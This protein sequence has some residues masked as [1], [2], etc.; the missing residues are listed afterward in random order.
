MKRMQETK[1]TLLNHAGA[2]RISR[3]DLISIPTPLATDTFKPVPHDQLVDLVEKRLGN[4]GMYIAKEEY[5]V[6]TAG[7][8]LFGT[9]TLRH[10]TRADFSFTIGLRTSN[11]KTLPVQM[12][13]GS[14]V[15]VCDNLSFS[16]EVT[17][18]DRK[19]T[20]GLN[21]QSEVYDGVDRAIMRFTALDTRIQELKAIE[22]SDIEAKAT[23]YDAVATGVINQN[24]LSVVGKHYFEPPHD[25]FKP[26][27]M[28]SLQNAGT[29]AIKSLRPNIAME[30]T[31]QWG[32]MFAL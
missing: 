6:Q 7:Q 18:C 32:K 5:A 9:I 22:I 2:V 12:V 31:I 20:A 8:K 24:L 28:W 10:Q 27:T 15:F 23:I 19:H 26:R 17:I 16:G 29:E 4:H 25:E 13:A 1:A 11:D 3:G 14:R 30:A 21:I